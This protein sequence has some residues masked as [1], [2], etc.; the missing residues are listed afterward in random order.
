[1]VFTL[2]NNELNII[3]IESNKR[4]SENKKEDS[5]K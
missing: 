1:M 5:T 4:G 2:I 3:S